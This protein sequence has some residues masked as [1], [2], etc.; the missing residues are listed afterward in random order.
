VT[1]KRIFLDTNVVLD[2]LDGTRM[3]HE[4]ASTLLKTAIFNRIEIAISEDMLSTLY[5]IHKDKTKCLR[6][7]EV[8]QRDWLVLAFGKDVIDQ[9]IKHALDE[10]IDLEDALQCLCAKEHHCDA[11]ITHDQKFY[12][13]S[14][15]IMTIEQF[16]ER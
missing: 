11:L 8:V 5:Y 1:Y 15:P 4:K 13:C 6:F 12:D 14:L 2:I 3:H 16:L 10:Q 7:L 9:A